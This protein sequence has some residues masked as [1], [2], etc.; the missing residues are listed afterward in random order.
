[1]RGIRNQGGAA[2]SL[3]QGAFEEMRS[4]AVAQGVGAAR[5]GDTGAL[6]RGLVGALQVLDVGAARSCGVGKQPA[7][8]L[9][10]RGVA[11]AVL[12]QQ[13]EQ[14][15]AQD[16]VAVGAALAGVDAHAHAVSAAVNIAHCQG[17]DLRDAQARGVHGLQGHAVGRVRAAGEE[18][19]YFL[20]R[21]QVRLFLRHARHGRAHGLAA[22]A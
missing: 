20:A 18:A 4:E 1:M 12:A 13:V 22:A 3:T 14:R 6:A 7:C 2:T 5:L 16:A 8:G 9:L 21:E 10:V 11:A 17:A 15:W 19:R